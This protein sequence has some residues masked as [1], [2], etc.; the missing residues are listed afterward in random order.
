MT[1]ALQIPLGAGDGDGIEVIVVLV[2]VAFSIISGLLQKSSKAKKA[3]QEQEQARE[4]RRQ[5]ATGQ[6]P[7][8]RA[9]AGLQLVAAPPARTVQPPP[10]ARAARPRP[11]VR[12]ADRIGLKPNRSSV[13]DRHVGSAH[14]GRL[15][16]AEASVAARESLLADLSTAE[17]ARQAMIYHEVFSLPKALRQGKE[18]WEM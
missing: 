3:A 7:P 1:D 9:R 5:R 13:E 10:P 8:A 11:E 16:N 6:A 17:A 12:A 18:L 2:F 4:R 15:S 14:L